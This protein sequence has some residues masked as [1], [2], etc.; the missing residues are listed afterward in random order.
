MCAV[1]Q[2]G[3]VDDQL[4]AQNIYS[5]VR[6]S[7]QP[8]STKP[9]VTAT[10]KID[11]VVLVSFRKKTSRLGSLLHS[12]ILSCCWPQ[13]QALL[14]RMAEDPLA[15]EQIQASMAQQ[16]G[17]NDALDTPSTAVGRGF[18]GSLQVGLLEIS[19]KEDILIVLILLYFLRDGLVHDRRSVVLKSCF[20]W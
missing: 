20:R 8:I 15:R 3:N 13:I 19:L 4:T 12:I 14:R 11:V 18:V 16:L 5:L 9:S 17:S 1:L 6:K 2:F 7:I 10:I